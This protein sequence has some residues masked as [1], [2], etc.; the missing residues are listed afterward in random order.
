[1]ELSWDHPNPHTLEVRVEDDHIDLMRHTNN[2]VYLQW[3]ERVAWSHSQSLGLGP[4][5]YEA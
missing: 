2:V 4:E 5:Q 1:M 3:L